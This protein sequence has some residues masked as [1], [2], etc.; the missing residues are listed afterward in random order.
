MERAAAV[1]FGA[2][3]APERVR[4]YRRG[5]NRG[6]EFIARSRGPLQTPRI[7]YSPRRESRSEIDS[8]TAAVD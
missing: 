7:N 8:G 2:R 3:A 5:S 4:L 1:V 6:P